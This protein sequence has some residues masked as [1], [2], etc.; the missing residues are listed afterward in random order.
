L[1]E[2]V[3]ATQKPVVLLLFSGRPLTLPWAFEHVPAVLATWFPGI[4][5]GPALVRT[6]FGD[7]AP[8]GRLPLSW[9]RSVGQEPLYYNALSTGRPPVNVDL[10]KPPFDTPS[11]FVSRYIDEQNSPQFPFGRGLTYTTFR[12]ASPQ[13]N[14]TQLSAR[15]LN[16]DLAN[17]GHGTKPALTV[18]AEITN[19]GSREAEETAQL[20]V[21]LEG[22]STAQPIRALKG[23]KR[24]KL[25]AGET[26]RLQ[27]DVSADALALWDID[28][29]F[30]V[31]PARVK[32]WISPDSAQGSEATLE[33]KP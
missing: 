29:K 11:K 12:Y 22:T 33:I 2:A 27:F 1:L 31:E 23:F 9:P 7:A 25:A 15:A 8:T 16:A 18:S 17:S 24:V 3:V 21:R 4:Q 5:A 20:Y 26:Q 28:N 19:T 13:L 6:L 30:V 14:A 10:T 32:L